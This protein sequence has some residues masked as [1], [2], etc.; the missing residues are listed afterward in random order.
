M[1]K[2]LRQID[3][4]NIVI[5]DDFLDLNDSLRI[6]RYVREEEKFQPAT[7]DWN[8]L[9]YWHPLDGNVMKSKPY[10][11]YEHMPAIY[12][13]VV[14]ILQKEVGTNLFKFTFSAFAYTA[15]SG[16][17]YHD[18]GNAILACVLY[19]ND[20]KPEW[21]GELVT[22]SPDEKIGMSIVPKKNRMVFIRKGV[23]HKIV[24]V[25]P[26]AGYNTRYA[27]AGFFHE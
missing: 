6:A 8:S 16:F 9:K 5:Q 14:D 19:L 27:L 11:E 21:G 18:D 22:Y 12:Q 7:N 13:K 3:R 17:N 25:H 20:W 15:G 23:K 4:K 24:P 2:L 26:S 1:S 10:T